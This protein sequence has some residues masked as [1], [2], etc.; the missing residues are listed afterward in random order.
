[1]PDWTLV[2]AKLGKFSAPKFPLVGLHLMVPR[3]PPVAQADG[4]SCRLRPELGVGYRL[5]HFGC[6]TYL[7]GRFGY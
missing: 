6:G 1:L 7:G 4:G 3:V 2:K 5:E